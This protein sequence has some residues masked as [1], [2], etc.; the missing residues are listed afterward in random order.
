MLR[1]GREVFT[2]GRSRFADHSPAARD[3]SA[4]IYVRVAFEEGREVLAQLDTGAAW[5]VLAPDLARLLGLSSLAGDPARM[6]TPLGLM[7]G[8]LVRIPFILQADEGESLRFDGT[9]FVSEDWPD[10]MTFLGYS[11][12]LDSVRFAVDPQAN[13]FYF[14]LPAE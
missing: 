10:G 7:E 12:L 9:F 2:T 11:G 13:H 6:R 8:Q 1:L 3:S 14:G 4:K 5:S